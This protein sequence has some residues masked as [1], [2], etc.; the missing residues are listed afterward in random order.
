[1]IKKYSATTNVSINVVLKSGANRHIAFS[2]QT[3]GGSV[4]YTEDIDIQE[5]MERHYK[6]GTLFKIDPHFQSDKNLAP[7][8]KV[9]EPTPKPASDNIE[10]TDFPTIP[11]VENAASTT[12]ENADESTSATDGT[13]AA[14]PEVNENGLKTVVV[15][16]PDAA[17]A[18]L[19]EHFGVSRTKLKF[20]KT[21]KETAAAHGIEFKGI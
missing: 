12:G 6:Y 13:E 14:D 18:Y 5:A 4:F 7:K 9:T 10:T 2:A 20:L 11:Q 21:I 3:G 8:P 16:D 1:M 17:K 15:S 19:A